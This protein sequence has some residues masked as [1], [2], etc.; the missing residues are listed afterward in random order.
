[1]SSVRY[2]LFISFNHVSILT[3][4]RYILFISIRFFYFCHLN[5]LHSLPRYISYIAFCLSYRMELNLRAR[6][7]LK[8]LTLMPPMK[9]KLWEL[10]T[11]RFFLNLAVS[12]F[13]LIFYGQWSMCY[14][15]LYCF[16]YLFNFHLSYEIMII[17]TVCK[18]QGCLYFLEWKKHEQFYFWCVDSLSSMYLLQVCF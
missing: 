5:P 11:R 14:V 6:L 18:S 8:A 16:N 15:I 1:M 13:D 9:A 17:M 10:R 7:T 12:L 4:L 2:A 3:S